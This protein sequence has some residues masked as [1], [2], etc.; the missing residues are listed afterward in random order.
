MESRFQEGVAPPGASPRARIERL[1]AALL[2]YFVKW[3][4]K[5]L[6]RRARRRMDTGDIV[7]DAMMGVLQHLPNLE[8]KDPHVVDAYIRRSI[9][10]RIKDE[11]HRSNKGEVTVA[12]K[13]TVA[14]PAGTPLDRFLSTE[15]EERFRAAVARLDP[16]EQALVVGRLDGGASY[17]ALAALTERP[18]AD[19]ARVATRRA[20]LRVAKIMGEI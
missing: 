1:I 8:G 10:N 13:L 14:D 2:P 17:E 18:S 3:S 19:A 6:P 9:L 15:D 7:Q 5:R 4:H 11:V 20:V 16:D 12:A